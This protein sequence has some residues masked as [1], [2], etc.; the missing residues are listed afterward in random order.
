VRI[1]NQYKATSSWGGTRIPS[2]GKAPSPPGDHHNT[3]PASTDQSTTGGAILRPYGENTGERKKPKARIASLDFVRGLMLVVSVAVNSLL[4]TPEWFDHAPWASVHP[5]D[6]VFP[7]FVTLSGCGL[8]FAMH[9]RVQVVPL[10]R[11][12]AILLVAGLLYNAVVLDSW[13]LDTWRVTGVLQLY[14]VVVAV[15]GIL[16]LV[17]RSWIGWAVITVVIAA[18]HSALLAVYAPGCPGDVLTPGCNPAGPIDIAVF[19]SQH[20]YHLGLSGH[21]PE[22]LVAIVGALVS[23]S[24]G[25]CIGHLML[26]VRARGRRTGTGV[27]AVVLPML[28]VAAA[29]VLLG[30][31]AA[32][33]PALLGGAE[34]PAMKRLWTAPFAMRVGAGAAIALMIGHVILDRSRVGKTLNVLSYP[35]IGLGRNSLLVYFGS[36]VLMSVLSRP[37]PSGSTLATDISSTIAV[38]DHRQ[39]TWTIVVLAFWILLASVLHRYK[40]YL[41]P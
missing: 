5:I 38:A 9:R 10:L 4:I 26:A 6:V 35:F 11:R 12:V 29:A 18:A 37:T 3:E 36:H 39:A 20:I 32:Q 15:M 40:V 28:A 24:L 27:R 34:L 23:A 33:L 1:N 7:L 22:G 31:V 41:R 16:H 17:T 8:A 2:D 21:D 30:E 19:G 25:A 14:A 13:Q